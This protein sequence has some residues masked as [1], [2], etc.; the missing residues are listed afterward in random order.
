MVASLYGSSVLVARSMG[1]KSTNARSCEVA[2]L[3]F[4]DAR[5]K[6]THQGA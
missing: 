5:Y 2:T 4:A 1:K 6:L 3:L